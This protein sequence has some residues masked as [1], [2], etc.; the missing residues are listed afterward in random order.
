MRAGNS[1][2]VLLIADDPLLR[3]TLRGQ[4]ESCGFRVC[5]TCGATDGLQTI[6]DGFEPHIVLTDMLADDASKFTSAMRMLWEGPVNVV[7]LDDMAELVSSEENQHSIAEEH[8]PFENAIL[9]LVRAA[10]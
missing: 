6:A 1:I 5:E 2:D 4:L 10:D 7:A 8:T 3:K 9:G